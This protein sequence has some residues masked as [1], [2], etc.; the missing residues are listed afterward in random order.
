MAEHHGDVARPQRARGAHIVEIP[1]AQEFRAH[2]VDQR[3]PV[4]V[5]PPFRLIP[6]RAVR[7]IV[8]AR[9]I[10]VRSGDRNDFLKK[11]S[12]H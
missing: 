10:P 4:R 12:L 5:V 3:S 6:P 7:G 11:P 2:D 9:D 8:G 1:R